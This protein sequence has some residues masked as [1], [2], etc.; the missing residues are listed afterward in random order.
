MTASWSLKLDLGN[1]R[2]PTPS[3]FGNVNS[4]CLSEARNCPKNTALR[5]KIAVEI[6]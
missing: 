1:Q 4:N 3:Y 6:I 2:L 5:E